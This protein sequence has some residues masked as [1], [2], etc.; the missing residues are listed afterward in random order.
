MEAN[1][2][3][4][5]FQHG[6]LSLSLSEMITPKSVSFGSAYPNPFNPS[7]TIDFELPLR[8]KVLI[9]VYDLNGKKV[10]SLVDMVFNSGYHSI[11]WN[12]DSHSSGV[13]FIKMLAGEY[14]ST[15]KLL[16]VK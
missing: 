3:T 15:Q 14:I 6:L 11:V 4:A 7:T 16:L 12:A 1:T 2:S 5:W 10:E 8:S 9:E 13:Y